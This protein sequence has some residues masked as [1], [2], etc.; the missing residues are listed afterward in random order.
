[1]RTFGAR[2]R[3]WGCRTGLRPTTARRP[4]AEQLQVKDK[5]K[6][7]EQLYLLGV[8]SR[9][10]RGECVRDEMFNQEKANGNNSAE[11][12]QAAEQER[13]S[14]TRAKWSDSLLD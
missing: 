10:S 8:S 11:R 9:S 1:M 6:A 3:R 7:G 14:L 5:R 12:M 2:R 13:V 4:N